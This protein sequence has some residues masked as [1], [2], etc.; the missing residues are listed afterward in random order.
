MSELEYELVEREA[1]VPYPRMPEMI[2]NWIADP[3]YHC[4]MLID[5]KCSVYDSRPTICR[6]WGATERMR[7]RWGCVPDYGWLSAEEQEDIM[8]QTLEIGCSDVLE[9]GEAR[10]FVQDS[11]GLP[12]LGPFKTQE[13]GDAVVAWVEEKRRRLK[14]DWNATPPSEA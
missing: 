4:P 7:C 14:G 5:G 3:D 8:Q 1:G 11:N 10:Y 12:V 6:L 9:T 2:E 13:E